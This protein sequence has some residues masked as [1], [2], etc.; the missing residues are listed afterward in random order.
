MDHIEGTASR[1]VQGAVGPGLVRGV[2]SGAAVGAL[3]GAGLVVWISVAPSPLES[4]TPFDV[5]V[6]AYGALI[7][8]VLGAAVGLLAAAASLAVLAAGGARRG[9]AL[10]VVAALVAALVSLV[11]LNA[12]AQRADGV[13]LSAAQTVV[14]GVGSAAIALWQVRGL[15]HRL[16]R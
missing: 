10:S 12:A 13:F 1:P 4:G 8:V 16:D 6:M 2:L 5:F 14:I 7:G 9:W 15:V 11:V 3:A